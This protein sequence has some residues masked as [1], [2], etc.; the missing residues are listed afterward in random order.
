[1]V[2]INV[3]GQNYEL[4]VTDTKMVKTSKTDDKIA[5]QIGLQIVNTD[6]ND[7]V[8]YTAL[9]ATALGN[10]LENLIFNMVEHQKL[11]FNSNR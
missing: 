2:K 7:E 9:K 8:G 3:N 10:Q 11:S 1:M 4:S 5:V 6:T